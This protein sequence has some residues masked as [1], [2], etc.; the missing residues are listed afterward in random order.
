M[1]WFYGLLDESIYLVA[2]FF[3]RFLLRW[4]DGTVD[5]IEHLAKK[6]DALIPRVHLELEEEIHEEQTIEDPIDEAVQGLLVEDITEELPEVAKVKKNE[7]RELAQI[8]VTEPLH[9]E[10]LD[11]LQVHNVIDAEQLE[12]PYNG[13]LYVSPINQWIESSCAQFDS[14]WYNTIISCFL[15]V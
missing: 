7:D 4:H 9:A 11:L 1:I 14:S 10:G 12:Q 8:Y 3:E 2:M 6:Y 15:T 13:G 5:E